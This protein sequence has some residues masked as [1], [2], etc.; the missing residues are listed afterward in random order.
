MD[1]PARPAALLLAATLGACS[2][3]GTS[4]PQD[5]SVEE[6]SRPID[7]GADGFGASACGRCSQASCSTETA[8]CADEPSCVRWLD[9]YLGCGSK[10]GGV[11]SACANACPRGQSSAARNDELAILSC[12]GAAS[13]TCPACGGDA[14]SVYAI[15]HED[16]PA[17]SSSSA[18]YKCVLDQCCH[19]LDACTADSDCNA[20]LP[21][22]GACPGT[23]LVPDAGPDAG[24]FPSCYEACIARYPKGRTLL[25]RYNVCIE[26]DCIPAAACGGQAQPCYACTFGGCLP[27]VVALYSAEGGIGLFNCI[28]QC[29][30][31]TCAA[32]CSATF[33]AATG[34]YDALE[35][36]QENLCG[37]FCQRV[38]SL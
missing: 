12:L 10:G 13:T 27:E 7:S 15:T 23:D 17:G 4:A 14:G 32:H 5:A 9:C 29:P 16:C 8:A 25:V 1:L 22:V 24:F 33:P 26:A 6:A 31:A 19:T 36:C 20:L 2:S 34:P 28:Q 18:C 3:P 38:T 11:D 21:C 37:N 35:S 30:D